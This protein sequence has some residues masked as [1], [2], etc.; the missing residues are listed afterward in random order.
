MIGYIMKTF[1]FY[2]YALIQ[3]LIE[4]KRFYSELPDNASMVK[5]FGFCFL[6]SSFYTGAS[7]LTGS[8][9][10]PVVTG[11]LVF[12]KSMGMV[13]VSAFVS[14]LM[15]IMSI[16]RKIEFKNIFSIHAFSS[17]ILL[18]MSW[19]SFFFWFAELWKWW[20]LYTGFR[21][22]GKLAW[23]PAVWILIITVS[24]QF[25]LFFAFYPAMYGQ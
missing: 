25:L 13:F 18:L 4:P 2:G 19:V 10:N 7:L 14:Y 6:C 17:G 23:K 20:L 11:S 3:I 22:A 16:G 15:M 8:Y 5:S 24:F 21:N 9:D 1:Q 12:L